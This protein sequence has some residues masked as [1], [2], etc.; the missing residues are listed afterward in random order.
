[1]RSRFALLIATAV[2]FAP[3][4]YGQEAP[5]HPRGGDLAA[6]ILAPTVDEGAIREVG[7]DPKHQLST[8]QSKRWRPSLTSAAIAAFGLGAI[9]LANFWAV[10]CHRESQPPRLRLRLRLSR[11]P[12][13]LQP[14]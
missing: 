4:W 7:S 3:G 6:R 9:A 13:R 8:R 12:P 10:A 2:V 1:M 11:A 5:Q 14:A